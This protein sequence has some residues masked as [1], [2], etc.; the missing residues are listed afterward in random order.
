V[1]VGDLVV[2]T[3]DQ[4]GGTPPSWLGRLAWLT[5]LEPD[6]ERG[7]RFRVH[8]V[9]AKIGWVHAVRPATPEEIARCQLAGGQ[10]GLL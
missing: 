5:A 4:D 3:E 9:G 10:A 1:K 7:P 2:V 6:C 8:C